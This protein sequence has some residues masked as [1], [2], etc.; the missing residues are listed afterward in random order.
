MY[1]PGNILHQP[2]LQ[3]SV[4]L[5][6]RMYRLQKIQLDIP[7]ETISFTYM[8]ASPRHALLM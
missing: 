1:A 4:Q 8:Q 3:M 2:H 7:L 6:F 5:Q